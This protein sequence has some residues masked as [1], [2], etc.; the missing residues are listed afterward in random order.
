LPAPHA[1]HETNCNMS[2]E[3]NFGSSSDDLRAL[4]AYHNVPVYRVAYRLSIHPATLSRYLHNHK[5]ITSELADA[6]KQAVAAE[7][8]AVAER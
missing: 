3:P 2:G 5:A 1:A 8:A 7:R 6:I 4:L